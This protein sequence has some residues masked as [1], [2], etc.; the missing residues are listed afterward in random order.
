MKSIDNAWKVPL[1]RGGI[2][3]IIVN[4]D[5][6][7]IYRIFSGKYIEEK[8]HLKKDMNYIDSL[9]VPGAT[10]PVE[11]EEVYSALKRMVKII[12][13]NYNSEESQKVDSLKANNDP[14]EY[15]MIKFTGLKDIKISVS[16]DE[17]FPELYINEERYILLS[18]NFVSFSSADKTRY[19]EYKNIVNEIRK[20][21]GME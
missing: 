20:E 6:I 16:G 12:S 14:S 9:L 19:E 13:D 7:E 18:D 21:T 15:Q 11:P 1:S 8:L 17:K 5:N 10:D 2:Y 4:E 3:K